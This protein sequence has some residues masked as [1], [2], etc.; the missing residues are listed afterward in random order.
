M[1]YRIM[2]LLK[3]HIRQYCEKILGTSRE[4]VEFTYREYNELSELS[5]IFRQEKAQ[6]DGFITSGYIPLITIQQLIESGE[7]VPTACF[8]IEVEHIY[9]LM[10]KMMLL[11]KDPDVNRIGIDFLE[12]GY[13]L[14]QALIEEK[15]PDMAV[16]FVQELIEYPPE[17]IETKENELIES[18]RKKLEHNELDLILTQFYTVCRTGESYG[19]PSYYVNPSANELRRTF[20][21]LKQQMKMKRMRGN[22]PGAIV[23]LPREKETW[24]ITNEEREHCLLELKQAVM[25]LNKKYMNSLVLKESYSG[26]EIYT[27][28]TL[29]KDMTDNYNSCGVQALLKNEMNFDGVISYGIGATLNQA[30]MNAWEAAAYG[31]KVLGKDQGSFLMD[32][33]E[34]VFLLDASPEEKAA[35]PAEATKYLRE[36]AGSVRLS[37][38]TISKLSS[39][40]RLEGSD[41][42]TAAQI[43]KSLGISPRTTSKILNNLVQ[44]GYAELIGQ[45][46]L[47]GKGRPVKHYRLKIKA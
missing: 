25:I 3:P 22:V 10:L 44:Y 8:N 6:Y 1:S 38:E 17:D 16:N 28:S 39:M 40:M 4:D 14:S 41:E 9:Q 36:V 31:K 30:R 23:I 43:V 15:L 5:S 11:K 45:E 20:F 27:N 47:G 33:N 7:E 42:V 12:D 37:V 19:I 24:G 13:T 32:E 34:T 21:S 18:Y 46:S 29:I 35:Q 26:Y 2:L